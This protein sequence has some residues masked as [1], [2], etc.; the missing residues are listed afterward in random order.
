MNASPPAADLRARVDRGEDA[1]VVAFRLGGALHGCDIQLVDE[2]LARPVIHPLPDVPED[3]LGVMLVRGELLPVVDVA[4]ALGLSLGAP[5]AV[6]VVGIGERRL[7]VAAEGAAEVVDVPAD[8][9]RPAPHAGGDRDAYVVGVA[10]V[11]AGLVTLIDLAEA[12]RERTIL[13]TGD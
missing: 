1:Q 13:H 2:V 8:A 4:P 5:G 3:L 7:G 10:R 6:L 12:L 11:R 9:L